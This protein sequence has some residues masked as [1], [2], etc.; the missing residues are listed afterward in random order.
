M[1]IKQAKEIIAQVEGIDVEF[2]KAASKLPISLFETICAFL[3]RKGGNIFLGVDDDGTILG[4]EESS[5]Q[6]QLDAL[7]RNMNNTQVIQP[8][9]FLSTEVVEIGSKKVIY[10]YVPESSQ[11]HSYKGHIYDRNEDGDF[12]LTN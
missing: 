9:F 3:N 8:T 5:I 1:T 2:K 6:I 12:K 7:A 4:V 11:P 10:I